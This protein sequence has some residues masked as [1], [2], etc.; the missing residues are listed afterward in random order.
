[1]LR[2]LLIDIAQWTN[3]PKPGLKCPSGASMSLNLNHTVRLMGQFLKMYFLKFLFILLVVCVCTCACVQ[4]K[5]QCL[6]NCATVCVWRSE[7]ALQGLVLS[8][9]HV[10]PRY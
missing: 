3:G 5:I 1:M 9:N 7:D 4:T 2:R 8:F 10:D 6:Q